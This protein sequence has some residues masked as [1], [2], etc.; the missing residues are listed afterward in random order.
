L[1]RQAVARSVSEQA[2]VRHKECSL[3]PSK[4]PVEARVRSAPSR[5]SQPEEQHQSRGLQPREAS[6]LGQATIRDPPELAAARAPASDWSHRSEARFGWLAIHVAGPLQ[7]APD[8][9]AECPRQRGNVPAHRRDSARRFSSPAI[10]DRGAWGDGRSV[11]LSR[12]HPGARPVRRTLFERSDVLP[13]LRRLGRIDSLWAWR[14]SGLAA[15]LVGSRA[16]L[17]FPR[18]LHRSRRALTNS[19]PRSARSRTRAQRSGHEPSRRRQRRPT[20]AR[21]ER[22]HVAALRRPRDRRPS[23]VHP[24]P[25]RSPSSPRR[26]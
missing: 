12:A 26:R 6:S 14:R 18:F 15:V 7:P 9:R 2:I 5:A 16:C 25:I 3:E 23:P 8:G 19:L 11:G 1:S 17:T 22:G 4:Q 20:T 21:T 10:G 13:V 24:P